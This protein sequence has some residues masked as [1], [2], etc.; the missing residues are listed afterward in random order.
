VKHLRFAS[1]PSAAH[2][3]SRRQLLVLVAAGCVATAAPAWAQ[4]PAGSAA[5]PE[6]R[7][8][9]IYRLIAAEKLWPALELSHALVRDVPNFRLAHLV[10]ADLLAAMNGALPG[11]GAPVAAPDEATAKELAALR[12]EA[13][14]RLAAHEAPPPEGTVPQNFVAL[15]SSTRHA[16]AVDASRSRLYFFKHAG[17][18]LELMSHHYVSL[19]RLGVN[20]LQEGDARTPLGVYFVTGKLSDQRLIDFYGSGALPLN[21]PNAFDR[22]R[23]RTGSGIWLHGVP[24]ENY[25]RTP[26]ATDGCVVLANE[27]FSRLMRTVS[28]AHTPVVIAQRIDWVRPTALDAQRK[29]A[30]SLLTGWQRVQSQPGERAS[31]YTDTAP[32]GHVVPTARAVK[33][34]YSPQAAMAMPVSQGAPRPAPNA[35]A[36]VQDLSVLSYKDNDDLIVMT[37][38]MAREDK[39]GRLQTMRQDWLRTPQGGKIVFEGSPG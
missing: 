21:Y 8:V 37:F 20:K 14:L 34:D 17:G 22:L 24:R 18:R 26:R 3:P 6:Q 35:A 28:P 2:A 32:I 4:V 1:T 5:S 30:Q 13:R 38:N 31:I 11:F 36:S 16:I 19:G 29:L 9:Q 12:E 7:L 10:H 25:A 27:D 15:P 23:G 33:V 39:G